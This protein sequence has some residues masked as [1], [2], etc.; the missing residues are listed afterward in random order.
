MPFD[1]F[2]LY[3]PSAFLDVVIDYQEGS[4]LLTT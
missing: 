2:S 4:R 1:V 3:A